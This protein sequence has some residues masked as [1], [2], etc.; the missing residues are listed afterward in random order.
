M[1][2]ASSQMSPHPD[3]IHDPVCITSP[4][5]LP[6]SWADDVASLPIPLLPISS[7]PVIVPPI[8]SKPPPRDLSVLR[9]SSPKPFSSLQRRNKR[10]QAP[11]SQPFYNHTSFSIPHQTYSRRHRFPPPQAFSTPYRSAQVYPHRTP[12]FLSSALNWESDPRLF[13]LSQALSALGW[14][15]P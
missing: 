7:P 13:E 2:V 15:R 10:S 5:S 3:P 8:L 11:F 1:F 9:S 4:P 6:L 14:V 12:R